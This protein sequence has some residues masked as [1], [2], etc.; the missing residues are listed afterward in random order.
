MCVIIFQAAYEAFKKAR[1]GKGTS[2]Y[3]RG[4]SGTTSTNPEDKNI[5]E[6][7]VSSDPYTIPEAREPLMGD[8]EV[9]THTLG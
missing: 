3:I 4:Q 1:E 7:Y 6:K 2:Q 9:G 5:Y 8:Q